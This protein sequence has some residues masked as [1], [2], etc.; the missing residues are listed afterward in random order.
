VSDESLHTEDRVPAVDRVLGIRGLL[1]EQAIKQIQ[2][3]MRAALRS[4]KRGLPAEEVKILERAVEDFLSLRSLA[5]PLYLAASSGYADIPLGKGFSAVYS[6]SD[7]AQGA[8]TQCVLR[9]VINEWTPIAMDGIPKGHRS[10]CLFDFPQGIPELLL[11]L[12]G[13]GYPT[14]VNV[15][16]RVYL[17]TQETWDL[18][19]AGA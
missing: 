19:K 7:P 13:V 17:C 6:K 9:A 8:A 15:E 16:E 5:A 4:A 10:V 18:R 3:N 12:P 14:P 1:A 2:Q 11:T